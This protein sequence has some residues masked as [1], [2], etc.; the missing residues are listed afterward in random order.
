M[1]FTSFKNF[2]ESRGES[3]NP[4]MRVLEVAWLQ[5][6]SFQIQLELILSFWNSCFG[7]GL[8]L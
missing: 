1:C 7:G 6:K 5:L 2:Q 4:E 3:W 8:G